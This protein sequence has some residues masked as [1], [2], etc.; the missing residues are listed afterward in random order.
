MRIFLRIAE[1]K[2]VEHGECFFFYGDLAMKAAAIMDR[3]FIRLEKDNSTKGGIILPESIEKPRTIGIVES[4]GE[5]VSAEVRVGDKVLFHIFDE[6]P[7]Y[8]QD[9]VVVR[10]SSILGVITDE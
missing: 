5:K 7:T 2:E 8:D 1:T 10:E 6:L 9:V 4:V 3:V